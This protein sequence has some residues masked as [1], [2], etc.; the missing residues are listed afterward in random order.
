[1]NIH[2]ITEYVSAL[3]HVCIPPYCVLSVVDNW[4]LLY[5]QRLA[6][7]ME[8]PLHVCFCLVPKFLEATIRQ[9]DFM[10]N[11]LKQV[12]KV[13]LSHFENLPMQYTEN[14]FQH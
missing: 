5:A 1:M 11:G 12:E 2:D 9:F 7:K 14:F 6:L 8:I 3:L 4:A 10:L 13:N